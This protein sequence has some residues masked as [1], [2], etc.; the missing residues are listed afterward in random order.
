MPTRLPITSVTIMVTTL[1][2]TFRMMARGAE[3]PPIRAPTHPVSDKVIT[4]ATNVTGI[5][6]CSGGSE[7]A[8]NGSM[9]PNANEISGRPRRRP[10]IHMLVGVDTE[11]DLRVCCQGVG[12]GE[13]TGHRPRGLRAE[14]AVAVKSFEFGQFLFWHRLEFMAF[15]CQCGALGVALRAHRGVLPAGHR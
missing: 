7:M 10:R 2:A 14:P 8:S 4:T 5:R 12:V 15:L 9:E 6:A 1:T 13:F 11:L 3:A